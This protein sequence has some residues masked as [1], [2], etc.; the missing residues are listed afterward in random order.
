[1]TLIGTIRCVPAL[2]S[3]F[4]LPHLSLMSNHHRFVTLFYTLR[5]ARA[6]EDAGSGKVGQ[7]PRSTT[8]LKWFFTT[9]CDSI[10]FKLCFF[11]WGNLIPNKSICHCSS[12]LSWKNSFLD[13]PRIDSFKVV[14]T[15]LWNINFYQKAAWRDSFQH[16]WLRG[17]CLGSRD[18]L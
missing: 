15:H 5:A 13:A 17:N 8:E 16:S 11:F 10:S 2:R 4:H 3:F 7:K 9:Q 12:I 18:M 6:V 1:M 14:S